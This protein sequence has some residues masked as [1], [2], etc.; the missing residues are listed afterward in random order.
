MRH[1][2]FERLLCL[3]CVYLCVC[4]S[5]SLIQ[6]IHS[7]F[8]IVFVERLDWRDG[9]VRLASQ[10]EIRLHSKFWIKRRLTIIAIVEVH[11]VHLCQWFIL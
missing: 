5:A 11:S 7:D 1:S 4:E 10:E 3:S 6:C 2:I 9:R 8:H